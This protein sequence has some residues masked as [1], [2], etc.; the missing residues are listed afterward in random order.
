MR[1][2]GIDYGL[3]NIGLAVADDETLLSVPFDT[4]RE[5][6]FERSLKQIVQLVQDEEIDAVVV[7]YPLTLA[8]GESEQ[9]A[10]TIDFL[11]ELGP[12]L[13]VPVHKEDERLTSSFA[14][15][16]LRDDSGGKYDEHALAAAAIL[17]SF[18][19]R[20]AGGR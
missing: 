7:G 4:I 10:K 15:T 9:A 1:Y 14:R 13:S 19:D 17:Q 2:L 11:D 18:L 6:D 12:R 3:A 16:L 8:G 20:L 5:T